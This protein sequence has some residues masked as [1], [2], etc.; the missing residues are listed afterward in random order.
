MMILA[1]NIFRGLF[2][3]LQFEFSNTE[4][5]F[6]SEFFK[7][8][9]RDY[10]S[11][12]KFVFSPTSWI[13]WS[14]FAYRLIKD[15]ILHERV[16]SK[17]ESEKTHMELA[18]L[19]AQI[20]PHFLFNTLNNLYA[21]S[22]EEK[23]AKTSDAITKMGALMR[24]NLHE[25]QSEMILL[26]KEIDYLQQ[27]VELQKL[28]IVEESGLKIVIDFELC[29]PKFERIAPMILLPFIENAF[30]F[31]VS[32]IENGLIEIIL[33]LDGG[34]LTL[35]VKNSIHQHFA[36]HRGGIG[37]QNVRNRLALV[38]PRKHRLHHFIEH[39]TYTVNLELD[40]K[41][42]KSNSH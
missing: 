35:H 4:Y 42:D 17:L 2:V 10:A 9:F 19:K 21:L 25:S 37:L 7:W 32:A 26:T 12:E 20:N 14:S 3:V 40:L 13:I 1:A 34:I 30:K 11:L 23:A 36:T 27:Y 6:S 31:G 8:A 15:W 5:N 41:D 18:F 16:K 22:L 39:D 38:Y 24:Y 28:R 33:K 29:S